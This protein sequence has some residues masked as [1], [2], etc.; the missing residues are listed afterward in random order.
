MPEADRFEWQTDL[1]ESKPQRAPDIDAEA[2]RL[3]ARDVVVLFEREN[4]G[5]WIR[6]EMA[7]LTGGSYR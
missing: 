6:M 1:S 2:D 7:G 5:A 4:M 3:G